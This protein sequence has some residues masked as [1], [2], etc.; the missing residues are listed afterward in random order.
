VVSCTWKE[1]DAYLK[2]FMSNYLDSILNVAHIV[3]SDIWRVWLCES[4]FW[5]TDITR[6]SPSFLQ[7]R[8]LTNSEFTKARYWTVI[9]AQSMSSILLL[10]I[11]SDLCLV[12]NMNHSIARSLKSSSF[13]KRRNK[14]TYYSNA[15][16]VL[17]DKP[18]TLSLTLSALP[19]TA[20]GYL[21]KQHV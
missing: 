19:L 11:Y 4:N 9:K 21:L 10:R 12:L 13:F 20:C 1:S 3:Q 2:C 18:M 8:V 6:N 14:F 5:A 7:L 17:R 15:L 16:H